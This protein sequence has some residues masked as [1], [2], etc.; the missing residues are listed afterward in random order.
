VRPWPGASQQPAVPFTA[1]ATHQPLPQAKA[2]AASS[3]GRE[4]GQ[5]DEE[6]LV[7]RTLSGTAGWR[8]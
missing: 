5:D 4:E 8:G 3:L 2:S 6:Q 7:T 1:L